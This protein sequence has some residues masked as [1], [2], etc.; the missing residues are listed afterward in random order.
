VIQ[1]GLALFYV[2]VQHHDFAE[3]IIADV[4]DNNRGLGEKLLRTSIE[5][6]C[7]KLRISG[8]QFWEDTDRGTANLYFSPDKSYIPLFLKRF[9]QKLVTLL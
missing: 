9:N 2:R 4:I 7:E 5:S 1:I 8:T 3:M 6:A